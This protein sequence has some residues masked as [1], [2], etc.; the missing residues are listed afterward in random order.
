MFPTCIFSHSLTVQYSALISS[1]SSSVGM[2]ETCFGAYVWTNPKHWPKVADFSVKR[3][4]LCGYLCVWTECATLSVDSVFVSQNAVGNDWYVWSSLATKRWSC[5]VGTLDIVCGF[6]F[7]NIKFRNK[8]SVQR[9]S[10][11]TFYYL[12][13]GG[14]WF[15]IRYW[16]IEMRISRWKS[17]I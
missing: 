16:N 5:A 12:E 6:L 4:C 2:R 3:V 11:V 8:I 9:N 10:A 1:L 14:Q 7:F 13:A 15:F 17:R